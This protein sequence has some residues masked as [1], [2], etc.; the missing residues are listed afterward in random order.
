MVLQMWNEIHPLVR[1]FI[2]LESGVSFWHDAWL[3]A[4][5]FYLFCGD[6]YQ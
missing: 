4:G 5:P 1:Y 2:S 6:G 3:S